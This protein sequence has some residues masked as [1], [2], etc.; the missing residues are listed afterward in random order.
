MGTGG[1]GDG[2]RVSQAKTQRVVDFAWVPAYR[3]TVEGFRKQRQRGV[4]IL[5]GYPREYEFLR[6]SGLV[7]NC[8]EAL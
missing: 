6:L 2:P 8:R 4:L 1:Q 5:R 7:A 3:G